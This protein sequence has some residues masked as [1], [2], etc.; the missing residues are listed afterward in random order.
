MNIISLGIGIF[1]LGFVFLQVISGIITAKMNFKKISE[2]STTA[3]EQVF[4]KGTVLAEKTFLSPITQTPCV[5]ASFQTFQRGGKFGK[6][7]RGTSISVGGSG[8]IGGEFF[9]QDETGTIEIDSKN[10]VGFDIPHKQGYYDDD[11]EFKEKITQFKVKYGIGADENREYFESLI[12]PNDKIT[13][14]CKT[15]PKEKAK[16]AEI[17][18]KNP[19]QMWKSPVRII[20]TAIAFVLGI[21][22]LLDGLK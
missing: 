12:L 8:S 19:K 11:D 16:A 2:L 17:Y 3:K 14:L 15:S 13:V 21:L 20:A 1:F 10:A 6:G 18:Y 5:Y 7:P 9:L 22:A 4:I